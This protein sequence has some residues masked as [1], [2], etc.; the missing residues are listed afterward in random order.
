MGAMI[1]AKFEAISARHGHDPVLV[2]GARGARLS[3]RGEPLHFTSI[4]R[5][6]PEF[7]AQLPGFGAEVRTMFS[8]K[9]FTAYL[10]EVF[11][12]KNPSKR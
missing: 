12:G 3:C 8:W 10:S 11:V 4:G 7:A 5:T 2:Q 9:T 1:M 6:R